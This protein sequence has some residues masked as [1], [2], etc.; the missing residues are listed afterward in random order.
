M[1]GMYSFP[2]IFFQLSTSQIMFLICG[3]AT[4]IIG[5]LFILLIPNNPM[6]SNLSTREKIYTIERLRSNQT[7]IENKKFDH[8]QLFEALR[9]PNV[10]VIAILM[11]TS[12]EINGALGNYSAA[13]IKSFGFTSKESALLSIPPGVLSILVCTSGAWLAGRTNQIL[14]TLM[15]YYPFGI[16]GGALMAFLPP[17]ARAAKMVGNYLTNMVPATPLI[18]TIAAANFS[19]HTKKIAV[20]AI[21][22]ISFSIGNIIGPL[23]FTGATAPTYTPAKIAM[24]ACFSSALILVFILRSMFA[25]ENKRRNRRNEACVVVDSEFKNMTDRENRGFRYSL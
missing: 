2:K 22:L 10:I 19:G 20:N 6:S 13:F 23:T 21:I 4:I 11:I 24:L 5:I 3:I 12:S 1:A 18:Y 16:I 14:L 9:D 15:C 8:A 7:G 17:S 25:Y